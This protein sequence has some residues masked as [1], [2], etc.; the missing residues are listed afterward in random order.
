MMLKKKIT[1]S[2]EL[3]YALGF[4]KLISTVCIIR[5]FFS[6]FYYPLLQKN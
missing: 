3:H 6:M 4:N 2:K 1:V 5:I